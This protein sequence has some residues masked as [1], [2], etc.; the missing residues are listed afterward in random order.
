MLTTVSRPANRTWL[1]SSLVSSTSSGNIEV[2][3]SSK[4]Y[5][6]ITN[7]KKVGKQ[8]H[9]ADACC[10]FYCERAATR[11]S[12]MVLLGGRRVGRR[13]VPIDCQYKPLL[14][15]GPFGHNLWWKFWLAVAR[16]RWSWSLETGPLSSPVVT[17]YRLS[18]LTIGQG[19]LSPFSQNSNFSRTD[20]LSNKR[21]HY[22]LKY[23]SCQKPKQVSLNSSSMLECIHNIGCKTPKDKVTIQYDRRV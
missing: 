6:K 17:S 12:T 4:L 3:V 8:L 19:Y 7:Y 2:F 21:W 23:T 11:G 20:R 13:Y 10:D 5:S 1:C 22:A 16:K 9:M 18:I 15:L 14:Y